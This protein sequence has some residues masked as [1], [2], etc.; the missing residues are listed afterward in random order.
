MSDP[1]GRSARLSGYSC[2]L[3]MVAV[4]AGASPRAVVG[5]VSGVVDVHEGTGRALVRNTTSQPMRVT[6][7]L[8]ESD[9]SGERVALTKPA[10]GNLWPTDFDLPPGETQVVR[11]AVPDDGYQAGTLLRLVTR[12]VAVPA[13]DEV[14]VAGARTR[15]V[16][17]TRVLS[18]VNVR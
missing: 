11:L 1:N 3:V 8:W 4:L 13:D 16:I 15:F 17:A 6:V 7:A 5:Q 12:M 18:K 2:I 10:R 9:E 14:E